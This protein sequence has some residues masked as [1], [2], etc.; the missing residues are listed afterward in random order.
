MLNP[1]RSLFSQDRPASGAPLAD[2]LPLPW[3]R[4]GGPRLALC[5][6]AALVRLLPRAPLLGVCCYCT[7]RRR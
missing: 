6:R 7:G 3:T 2:G 5:R 4:R 1:P